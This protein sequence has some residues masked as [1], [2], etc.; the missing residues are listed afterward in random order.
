MTDKKNLTIQEALAEVQRRANENRALRVAEMNA[1]IVGEPL[2]EAGI[3][4]AGIKAASNFASNL[5]RGATIAGPAVKAQERGAAGK[6]TSPGTASKAGL[7]TGKALRAHGATAGALGTVGA[8]GAIGSSMTGSKS[9][10][11]SA[12]PAAAAPTAKTNTPGTQGVATGK[13]FAAIDKAKAASAKPAAAPKS[14]GGSHTETSLKSTSTGS[15]AKIQGTKSAKGW[16]DP[17]KWENQSKSQTG[18]MQQKRGGKVLAPSTQLGTP[19]GGEGSTSKFLRSQGVPAAAASSTTSASSAPSQ[20][21]A[22]PGTFAARSAAGEMKADAASASVK[23]LMSMPESGKKI[24]EDTNSHIM[25]FLELMNMNH[26]NVFEAAKHLSA[27]QKKIA[28]VAGDPEKIDADDFKAL[29]SK[30]VEE[31]S[32]DYLGGSTV[33]KEKPK[34]DPSTPKTPYTGYKGGNKAGEI[35]SK[36]K[37]AAGMK[38][39]VTFSESELEYFEAVAKKS[40]NVRLGKGNEDERGMGDTV[41][42]TDVTN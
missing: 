2:D 4:S 11:D 40:A 28:G 17:G 23:K 8:A 14:A 39:D 6:F 37:G 1:E 16:A 35:I 32:K 21:K 26:G 33:T 15:Q 18:S 24:K 41:S 3:L 20:S 7:A 30:K 38:E 34:E 12:K 5:K 13:S 31:E 29:R 25:S 27:K 19:K 9:S 42:D 22:A 36:A 10:S